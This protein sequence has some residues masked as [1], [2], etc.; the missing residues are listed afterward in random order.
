MVK[1][2]W[3]LSTS[4]TEIPLQKNGTVTLGQH[5]PNSD[6]LCPQPLIF[7]NNLAFEMDKSRPD[8]SY[9]MSTT[10]TIAAL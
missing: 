6:S 4:R 10:V 9:L 2:K 5:D 1:E 8:S 3:G 7:P